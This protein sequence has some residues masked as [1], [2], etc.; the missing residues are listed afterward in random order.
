M[1]PKEWAELWAAIDAAP[2]EWI[3]TTEA[4]A[5]SMLE[6]VPPRAGA[7]GAF[8]VGEANC[9]GPDGRPLYH[10]FVQRGSRHFARLMSYAQ[11]NAG[12]WR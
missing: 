4:M 1:N 12:A 5:W 6:C 3:E 2:G 11:F 7:M 10:C 9:D 8:L